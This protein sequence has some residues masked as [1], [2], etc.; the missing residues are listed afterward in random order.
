MTSASCLSSSLLPSAFIIICLFSCTWRRQFSVESVCVLLFPRISWYRWIHFP[1]TVLSVLSTSPVVVHPF[2]RRKKKKNVFFHVHEI[3]RVVV[4]YTSLRL[5]AGVYKPQRACAGWASVTELCLEACMWI[6]RT[7][8]PQS[9]LKY[10]VLFPMK[11]LGKWKWKWNYF[12]VYIKK[13]N[14]HGQK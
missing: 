6:K 7:C 11:T 12:T 9:T 1:R 5:I 3:I 10:F 14:K 8:L 4:L 13:K 2:L